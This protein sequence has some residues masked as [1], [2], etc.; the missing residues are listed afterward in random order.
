MPAASELQSPEDKI[1]ILEANLMQLKR[2]RNAL[3]P[4][5]R[6]PRKLFAEVFSL[7]RGGP[8]LRH[9]DFWIVSPGKGWSRAVLVCRVFRAIAIDT[10]MLWNIIDAGKCSLE[11]RELCVS[12]SASTPLA[13]ITI[14]ERSWRLLQYS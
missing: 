9:Q 3:V 6:L 1:T 11:W 4:I 5:F 10:P 2:R 12:R 14:N 7:L 8:E 13:L